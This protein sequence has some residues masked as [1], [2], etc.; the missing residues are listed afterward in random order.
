MLEGDTSE[1]AEMDGSF[2]GESPNVYSLSVVADR[3]CAVPQE[4]LEGLGARDFNSRVGSGVARPVP[5][6]RPEPLFE[7]TLADRP[8]QLRQGMAHG[9]I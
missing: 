3:K 2:R 7:K 8:H 1:P 9:A 4:H 6:D 5:I